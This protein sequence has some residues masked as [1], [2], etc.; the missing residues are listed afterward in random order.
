[1]IIY[2]GLITLEYDPATDI[3]VT[4]MPD[5]SQFTLP[6][7]RLCLDIITSHIR[8]YHI[9]K[10]L[11][12]SSKT[13]LDISADDEEYKAL[14]A[15]FGQDILATPLQ[16]IARLSVP[17]AQREEQGQRLQQ[18]SGGA[19]DIRTFASYSE[20]MNWLLEN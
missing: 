1:M 12:D 9:K 16:K 17:D 15:K 11:F 5:V 13:T 4:N 3:L 8:N 20:A 7:V 2:S 19:I 10:A 14:S 6:E 18:V